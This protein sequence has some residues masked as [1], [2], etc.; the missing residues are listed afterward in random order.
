MIAES[1]LTAQEKEEILNAIRDSESRTSGEIRLFLEDNC[2]TSVL[3]RAAYI[4]D[5]LEIKNTALHNG[6]LIYIAVDDHRF[7]IIGDSG[8]HQKVGDAFWDEVRDE[9][10]EHFKAG[11]FKDGILHA[12]NTVGIK[13][14]E[15]FPPGISDIN[16][17]PDDIVFGGKE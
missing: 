17:L 5:E 10:R 4:F 8:I 1:L 16:E 14:S 15:F 11:R 12:I 6:V 13:L 7:C 3:D 2:T 9:M